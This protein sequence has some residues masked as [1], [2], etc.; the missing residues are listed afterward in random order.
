MV[1][2]T[3][4]A[5]LDGDYRVALVS[6]PAGYGKTATLAAWAAAR[7]SDVA[8]LSCDALDAE[9][10]RF[11][12]CLLTTVSTT[13]PGV[14]DDAFVLLDRDGSNT[15]DAAVSVANELA[16]IDAPGVIVI[17]DLHLAAPAPTMLAAF[18]D[19][20]PERFRFVAGTRADPPLPLGR[21]RIR[22]ELL[23]LRG[24]ELA[25][26]PDELADFFELQ[27]ITFEDDELGRLHELT[28]GWPA[29]AQLA[30]IALQRG[31]RRHDFLDAFASTDRAVSD[32]LFSEVLASLP[33]DLVDFLVETSV[34]EMFD[35]ELCA[36][37]TGVED[38]ALVL[39]RLIGA[40]LFIVPLDEP[41][42]WFRYHHLFGAFL[43]ARLAS[44]GRARLRN[45]HI[46]ASAA[47]EQRGSVAGAL[48]HAMAI[49]DADRA[50]QILRSGIRRSFDMSEGDGDA[51]PAVRLWLHER[52][53]ECVESDPVL[54]LELLI[55]LMGLTRP[56]DAPMWLQRITAAHPGADEQLVALIEGAWSEHH[57]NQGQPLEAIHHLA[58][59]MDVVD[60]R[61]PNAG[62]LPLL[63]ITLARAHIQAGQLDRAAAVLADARV[64]SSGSAIAEVRNRGIAAFVA[65]RRRRAAAGARAGRRRVRGRR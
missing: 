18:I 41:G 1:R 43:R 52:G 45:A 61:P 11:M 35:A 2:P 51:V 24:D 22:G 19:A 9:P 7:R 64:H 13:W 33:P 46:Q 8:W 23:E 15:Y 38:A 58:M 6:A 21:L 40:N 53:D 12:S 32:F 26:D 65:A 31:A 59:A 20:L 37:V 54:I 55:G 56:D 3:L 25:F 63:P 50:G 5:R 48:R 60:G 30:A 47:L 57:Q 39:D 36:A 44:Y 42:R 16:N 62:L 29:G 17:D 27:D 10:T 34:F 14:A 28:E 49:G 4:S